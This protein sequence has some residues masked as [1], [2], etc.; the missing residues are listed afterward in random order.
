METLTSEI[1]ANPPATRTGEAEVLEAGAAG[2]I[3]SENLR[4]LNLQSRYLC[5]RGWVLPTQLAVPAPLIVK[6]IAVAHT[7]GH[8]PS[9]LRAPGARDPGSNPA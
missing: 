8:E 1:A 5:S 3:K 7:H 4:R 2:V 9:A 6:C